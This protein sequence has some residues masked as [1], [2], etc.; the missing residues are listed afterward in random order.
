MIH[1]LASA[2][3]NE[4]LK[5]WMG[6]GYNRRALYLHKTAQVITNDFKGNVLEAVKLYDQLPGVGKYT[7]RAIR[8]FSTNEDIAT[9]DTNIRRIFIHEF[10]LPETVRDKELYDLAKQVLPQGRSRD[11]HNALMDYGSLRLTSNKTGI[12]PKTRQSRFEGSDRQIRGKILRHLLREPQD[13][14]MLQQNFDI[15]VNRLEHLLSTMVSEEVV[16]HH[17]KVYFIGNK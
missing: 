1:H 9:V 12:K 3:F 13:F 4:V 6:L 8:I 5:L 17:N 10:H 2:P 11:W 14:S 15:D 16:S 7:A